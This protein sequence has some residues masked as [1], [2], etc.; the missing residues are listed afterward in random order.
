MNGNG[1]ERPQKNVLDY[2]DYIE[3]ILAE[4]QPMASTAGLPVLAHLI[5]MARIEA[6]DQMV[7][8][9]SGSLASKDRNGSTRIAL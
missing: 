6:A 2:L 9:K 5:E 4:L 1:K 7:L 8:E 3:A